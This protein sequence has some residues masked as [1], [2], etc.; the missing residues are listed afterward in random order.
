MEEKTEGRRGRSAD[1]RPEVTAKTRN[2]RGTVRR[3]ARVV[4]ALGLCLSMLCGQVFAA[5]NGDGSGTAAA[6]AA[7]N[8]AAGNTVT[9]AV[10][11]EKLTLGQ[12]FIIE[13]TLVTVPEGTKASRVIVNLIEKR[14]PGVEAPLKMTGSVDSAFYLSQVYDPDRGAPVLP[15][16]LKKAVASLQEETPG[17]EYLGEFDYTSM[18][19][20]MYCIGTAE[21]TGDYS[22]PNVGAADWTLKDGQ[23]MRW[24]FTLYGYG[25][26]LNADNSEWGQESIVKAGDKDGLIWEVAELNAAYE[27]TSLQALTAYREAMETL[28][29]P[30]A[31]QA[32]VDQ[33]LSVLEK[34]DKSQLAEKTSEPETA[35]FADMAGHWAEGTVNGLAAK[36]IVKGTSDTTFSPENAITRGEFVQLLY[37]ISGS[38]GG[39]WTSKYED[40]GEKDWYADA[41]LWAWGQGLAS[42]FPQENGSV[43]FKPEDSISRQD[44]AVML[45]GYLTK[46]KNAQ[47]PADGDGA[48]AAF[49][50][51]GAIADY[52]VDPVN[53][54]QRRGIVSGS[55]ADGGHVFEPEK[56]STRAEAAAVIFKCL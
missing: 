22:F 39:T 42:G 17:D 18:S 1:N 9:V 12:G 13:P 19:G 40:V 31:S 3:A 55:S 32:E 54:L 56:T 2:G 44:M 25:A 47:P 5:E 4:L 48:T 8:R 52:A 26:D 16:Y 29:R 53:L 37:N 11:M 51:A 14:Y 24:Q 27:K 43:L 6:G 49:L 41:V 15:E 7:G 30:G 21:K 38:P 23:I 34:A 20:W 28:E 46:V 45:S 50:D 33:A 36:G 35:G 10:T